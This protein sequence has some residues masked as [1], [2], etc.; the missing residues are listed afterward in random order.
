LRIRKQ[1][2]A[3]VPLFFSLLP[4]FSK[5]T[6]TTIAFTNVNHLAVAA[7][8]QPL[9][10]SSPTGYQLLTHCFPSI[11]SLFSTFASSYACLANVT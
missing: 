9:P 11:L 2:V 7:M 10:S 4:P 3:A 6:T 1:D 8:S 5:T